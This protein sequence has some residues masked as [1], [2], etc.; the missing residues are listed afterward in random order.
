MSISSVP[1][2][3]QEIITDHFLPQKK[4]ITHSWNTHT[5][6][7]KWHQPLYESPSIKNS[8][9][10]IQDDLIKLHFDHRIQLFF[11]QLI[12]TYNTPF[13]FTASGAEDQIGQGHD[14]PEGKTRAAHS[15]TLPCLYACR[16]CEW[17]PGGNPYFFVYLK[18]SHGY[19]RHNATVELPISV[20]NT[21]SLVDGKTT[22]KNSFRYKC[23]EI[24]NANAKAIIG[25]RKGLKTFLFA[26]E[27]KITEKKKNLS[28]KDKRQRVLD[29]YLS[30]CKN[31]KAM[32]SSDEKWF[33]EMLGVK[34]NSLSHEETLRQV[35]FTNRFSVIK[36]ID[37]IQSRA[38][39]KIFDFQRVIFNK[40]PKRLDPK[41]R[42]LLL[43]EHS[44]YQVTL[45]KMLCT[46]PDQ[47][48]CNENFK[49]QISKLRKTHKK[50]LENL[51]RDLRALF[52]EAIKIEIEFR[53]NLFKTLRKGFNN[54]SQVA[55]VDKY[56]EQYPTKRMSQSMV[57]RLEGSGRVG[58]K[59]FYDTPESQRKKSIT[60]EMAIE[61]SHVLGID[62]GLF[63]PSLFT[64]KD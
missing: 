34:I 55:F 12:T 49:R 6:P 5:S 1:R 61:I 36:K 33:D 47:L 20:N 15:S 17:K 60:L 7:W 14:Y 32:L 52:R 62:A 46:S 11:H 25:P 41:L 28:N 9:H 38:I 23:L 51:K 31:V 59:I 63:L 21:D 22:S 39:K 43:T 45:R 26:L 2:Q 18:Y 53:A 44:S 3:S 27:K 24:I 50:T 19:Q 4:R 37:E 58:R 42:Y 29:I 54:L 48:R 30:R 8:P 10:L 40:C 13:Y 16:R 56:K 64:S 35:V 57:S